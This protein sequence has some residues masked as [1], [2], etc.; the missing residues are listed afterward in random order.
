MSC[1]EMG[2]RT[3]KAESF[4]SAVAVVIYIGFKSICNQNNYSKMNLND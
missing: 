4:A 2:M 1:C 3:A